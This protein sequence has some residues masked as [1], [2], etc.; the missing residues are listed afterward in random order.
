MFLFTLGQLRHLFV[1][2]VYRGF[3]IQV[4]N[5]LVFTSI[6]YTKD[7][8]RKRYVLRTKDSK[9]LNSEINPF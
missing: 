8:I 5:T 1:C 2:F 9:G 6:K 7:V 4:F 3:L